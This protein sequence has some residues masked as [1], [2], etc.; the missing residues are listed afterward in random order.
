MLASPSAHA[1][2]DTGLRIGATRA[3]LGTNWGIGDFGDIMR[4]DGCRKEVLGPTVGIRHYPDSLIDGLGFEVNMA[5]P[6]FASDT[7][8]AVTPLGRRASMKTRFPHFWVW[9][10]GMSGLWRL[11]LDLDWLSI[12]VVPD[13]NFTVAGGK[14]TTES[15]SV[16]SFTLNYLGTR[17]DA[18]ARLA[19]EIMPIH[20]FAL[21]LNAGYYIGW[22]YLSTAVGGTPYVFRTNDAWYRVFIK[23]NVLD[24]VNAAVL[25]YF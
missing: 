2:Y 15:G 24:T 9:G 4:L 14:E 12:V 16:Y 21:Q 18:G 25:I 23:D 6:R 3:A 22:R 11:P 17:L 13:V 8:N 1:E 7:Y 20:N 5:L 10:I 19:V